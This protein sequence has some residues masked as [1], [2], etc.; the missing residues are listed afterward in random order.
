MAKKNSFGQWM[1][2]SS[3]KQRVLFIFLFLL[4]FALLIFFL[5]KIVHWGSKT[6]DGAVVSGIPGIASVQGG[7]VSPEY[8]R[9]LNNNNVQQAN[10]AKN[11]GT[12]AIPTIINNGETE[13]ASI[14]S[15]CQECCHACGDE[16]TDQLLSSLLN[17]GKIS[18]AT[19][20]LLNSLGQKN[21]SPEDYEAE[22]TRL[23]RE[24][25]ISPEEARQLLT[26]YQKK[27]QEKVAEISAKDLD[28]LVKQ[29]VLPVGAA[30]ALLELQKNGATFDTYAQALQQLIDSG[31]I[32][33]ETAKTLQ[34]TYQQ[35]QAQRLQSETIGQL[36][37]MEADG[38][39]SHETAT[40]LQAL[41][42]SGLS[43]V[44]YAAALNKLVKESKLSPELAQRLQ[45]QYS[46]QQKGGNG[47]AENSALSG[48][49]LSQK[50]GDTLKRLQQENASVDRV[51][52]QLEQ[53]ARAN[54]IS[55]DA[56]GRLLTGYQREHQGKQAFFDTVSQGVAQKQLSPVLATQIRTLAS[57]NP[58]AEQFKTAVYALS[59]RG[60]LPDA[61][62]A[63]VT[64]AYNEFKAAEDTQEQTIAQLEAKEKLPL[65]VAQQLAQLR[66][67]A[68]PVAEY[69]AEL[70][71]LVDAGLISAETAKL[72]LDGYKKQ[73]T[74]SSR[75]FSGNGNGVAFTGLSRPGL[76][77][78][79]TSSGNAKLDSIAQASA[80][81]QAAAQQQRN[82]AASLALQQQ[83]QQAVVNEQAQVQ[84]LADKMYTQAQQLFAPTL[85]PPAQTVVIGSGD[86]T[87]ASGVGGNALPVGAQASSTDLP[88]IK[89]GTILY[90][91]LDTAVDSDYAETP[92]MATIVAGQFKGA[93]LL[94]SIKTVKD[95]Q[96]VML[97]FN[98][99]T[100]NT[101][102][103]G[104]A[105]NAFAIDPDSARTAVATSVDNHYMLRYGTAFAAAFLQGIGQAVQ[106]SGTTVT[107]SSG[108]VTQSTSTLNTE[109]TILI[110]LGQAGQSASGEIAKLQ[111]TAPTVKVKAGVSLGILFMSD[112]NAVDGSVIN[113]S[114]QPSV[115]SMS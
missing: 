69:A 50:N 21:L 36:A 106:E 91:V 88:M 73:F 108:V 95:G 98:L 31:Q 41:Q 79:L 20:G 30:S 8:E 57:T 42:A 25:K 105:I 94:G 33:P 7:K 85:N 3:A 84:Q 86:A 14:A 81:Q 82:Y 38:S 18:S 39:V 15:G 110:A 102:P 46:K 22:L 60:E 26:A 32:S 16:S 68:V 97:T 72:L 96:R 109:E 53:Y 62:A 75:G 87:S 111:N 37:S 76:D 101:W 65:E 115:Q 66:D 74:Q 83:N 43:S 90:G 44:D 1:K 71:R 19:A 54:E 10:Y 52:A 114:A 64:N 93:K 40:M 103:K 70:Q 112:V 77:V 28:V 51:A 6:S 11:T 89:A 78:N 80:G 55:A 104:T 61:E 113:T 9:A 23:V 48:M 100:M 107:S 12:S 49:E 13:F 59:A 45:A 2:K 34:Q 67:A 27:Y 24:G 5:S 17:S 4:L 99:M 56:A 92:I 63:L 58:S 35:Q 29:G 47:S